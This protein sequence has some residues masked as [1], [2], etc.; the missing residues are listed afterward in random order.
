M[1]APESKTLAGKPF[2]AYDPVANKWTNPS[3]KYGNPVKP[4]T[5]ESAGSPPAVAKLDGTAQLRSA[6][7]DISNTTPAAGAS[8]I[9]GKS[10][11]SVAFDYDSLGFPSKG[12]AE[13]KTGNTGHAE[14]S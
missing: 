4:M 7:K 11:P 8:Q 9:V 10:T 2:F 13:P 12:R 1:A 14:N 3:V 6:A 5:G